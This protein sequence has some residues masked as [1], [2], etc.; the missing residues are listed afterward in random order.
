MIHTGERP[1]CCSQCGRRFSFRQ[2]LDRHRHTHAHESGCEH[3]CACGETFRSLSAYLQH[4]QKHGEEDQQKIYTDDE[5]DP[6]ANRTSASPAEGQEAAR[7]T[8]LDEVTR[9]AGDSE[10]QR[11]ASERSTG[12]PPAKVRTSGR[13]RKPTMKIQVL[14]LEKGAHRGKKI[15]KTGNL[16]PDW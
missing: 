8:R 9:L 4:Q 1:H 13:K 6:N 14:N 12:V 11:G 15:S 2:S 16:T 10:G 7:G 5:Y 3:R